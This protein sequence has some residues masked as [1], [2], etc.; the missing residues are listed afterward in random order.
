MTISDQPSRHYTDTKKNSVNYRQIVDTAHQDQRKFQNMQQQRLMAEQI[1][2]SSLQKKFP[3]IKL[4]QY[5]DHYHNDQRLA[6]V[7]IQSAD[8]A[9]K[10]ANPKCPLHGTSAHHHHHH[11][12]AHQNPPLFHKSNSHEV[13][14]LI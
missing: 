13:N 11:P 9:G 6:Y 12:T 14:Y 7:K 4:D 8:D 5:A 1:R 2:N 3:M 10:N